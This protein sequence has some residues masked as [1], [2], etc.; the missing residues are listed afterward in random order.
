MGCGQ[1]AR[2]SIIPGDARSWCVALAAESIRAV[3]EKVIDNFL[4]LQ[5]A[6]VANGSDD[7]VRINDVK[8]G[9]ATDVHRFGGWRVPCAHATPGVMGPVPLS[10]GNVFA[11]GLFLVVK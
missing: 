9:N 3:V 11:R 1:T 2:S 7:A 4:Q 5:L 6:R 8:T 10:P